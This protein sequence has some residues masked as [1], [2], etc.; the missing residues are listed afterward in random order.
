MVL[1]ASAL[2][3]LL[4]SATSYANEVLAP[5]D[6][7]GDGTNELIR[8]APDG[9]VQVVGADGSGGYSFETFRVP[10]PSWWDDSRPTPLPHPSVG[11]AAVMPDLNTNG[12]GEVVITGHDRYGL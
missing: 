11:Q 9:V 5:G 8:V 7:D 10:E 6:L 12:S 2:L 3:F 1:R 4:C